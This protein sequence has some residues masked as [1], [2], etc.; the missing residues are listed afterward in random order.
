MEQGLALFLLMFNYR[1]FTTLW[2]YIYFETDHILHLV[3][4]IK[5]KMSR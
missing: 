1:Q 2:L 4:A 5:E 3:T